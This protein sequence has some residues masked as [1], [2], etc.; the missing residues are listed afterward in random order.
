MS[1]LLY[2]VMVN[3]VVDYFLTHSGRK[4]ELLLWL[5]KKQCVTLRVMQP[6]H[7]VGRNCTDSMGEP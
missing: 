6:G 5:S 2:P 1:G 7:T 3:D 4:N